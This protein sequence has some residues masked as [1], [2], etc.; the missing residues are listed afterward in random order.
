MSPG[1]SRVTA[2]GSASRSDR[3]SVVGEESRFLSDPSPPF[4]PAST[5]G[6]DQSGPTRELAFP[7]AQV[8]S[9]QGGCARSHHIPRLSDHRSF[10]AAVDPGSWRSIAVAR[11]PGRRYGSEPTMTGMVHGHH[12]DAQAPPPGLLGEHDDP[13]PVLRRPRP[14]CLPSEMSWPSPEPGH[15]LDNIYPTA[16]VVSLSPVRGDRPC[17]FDVAT[18]ARSWR[19]LRLPYRGEAQGR[20]P[21]R[22]RIAS[23]P[24]APVRTPCS[25]PRTAASGVTSGRWFLG[26]DCVRR[27]ATVRALDRYAMRRYVGTR[28]RANPLTNRRCRLAIARSPIDLV[29]GD[30]VERVRARP[31][32]SRVEASRRFDLAALEA[33]RPFK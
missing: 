1:P 32:D 22:R 25:S 16:E 7:T 10:P 15:A 28:Q 29:A 26:A 14:R 5:L 20:R 23:S 33:T 9:A 3:S 11:R 31:G 12:A 8:G 27:L 6:G 30:S 21:M 2:C 17:P 13:Q 24:A 18:M 4:S 19:N